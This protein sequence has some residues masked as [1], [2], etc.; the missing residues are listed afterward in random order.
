MKDIAIYIHIP[1][2]RSKCNYCAFNSFYADKETQKE[3]INHLIKEIHLFSKNNDIMRADTVYFGGGTP[4][5]LYEGG[6]KSIIEVLKDNFDYE[7]K[8]ISIECNP[9]SLTDVKL[10]EYN[11]SGINRISIG[12]QS[13]SNQ[14]LKE[15]G[16]V[17][18][19][20][21]FLNAL[22]RCK[23]AGFDNVNCDIM[24]GLP[25]QKPQDVTQTLQLLFQ[26][27]IIKHISM[28]GLKPEKNTPWQDIKIDEDLSA[29]MYDLAFLMLKE[30]GFNRYE[31]SNFAKNGYE[32]K[33]NIKYWKRKNYIGFGLSAHSLIDNVRYANPDSMTDYIN[34][35]KE[36][37]VLN[38]Q[39]IEEEYLMLA[40]RMDEGIDLNDYKQQFNRDFVERFSKPIQKIFKLK[41]IEIAQNN[42]RIA[43]KYMGVMNSI[44]T[45]FFI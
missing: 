38:Q 35:K 17:H 18:S 3:Y 1:F 27:D 15:A 13:A 21:D 22:E 23:K 24:L 34:G 16:R 41:V 4:S 39:Q 31:I 8:E 37:L 20:D 14:L 7:P 28:Y 25:N 2:C 30:N 9:E 45:E 43:P 40:L 10:N 32:C 5:F 12:L 42:L 29:D 26:H 19:F 33:H 6:I 36:T 11:E 44:I